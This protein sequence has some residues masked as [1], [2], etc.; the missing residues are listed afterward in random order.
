MK[1]VLVENPE[2]F[3]LVKNV[4]NLQGK[5]KFKDFIKKR[6]PECVGLIAGNAISVIILNSFNFFATLLIGAY[7]GTLVLFEKCK[8]RDIA[9][10][11]LYQ[12]MTVD[13]YTKILD[14]LELKD[15]SNAVILSK[16]PKKDTHW[17][18]DG[19]GR[20]DSKKVVSYVAI[21]K[22]QRLIVFKQFLTHYKYEN[23]KMKDIDFNQIFLLEDEDLIKERIVTKDGYLN[24]K[25][26]LGKKL[27]NSRYYK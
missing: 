4:E 1:E 12:S 16:D 19:K 17:L 24:A 7:T 20:V 22:K 9:R 2:K 10:K 14:D 27:I 6:W 21:P 18:L 15:F 26:S 8:N 25:N 13:G 23:P 3:D 5:L 11:N